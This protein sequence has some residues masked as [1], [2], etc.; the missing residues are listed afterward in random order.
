MS[1]ISHTVELPSIRTAI[2]RLL[3]R[4]FG[5]DT[6]VT[7]TAARPSAHCHLCGSSYPHGRITCARTSTGASALSGL[8]ADAQ[9]RR[10]RSCRQQAKEEQ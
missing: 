1:E 7:N 6:R 4:A 5:V 8:S 10:A 3:R 2:P 9:D